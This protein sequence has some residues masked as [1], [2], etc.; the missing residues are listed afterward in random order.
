MN[1]SDDS[2][3]ARVACFTT[4][5]RYPAG[6]PDSLESSLYKHL[7]LQVVHREIACCLGMTPELRIILA[8]CYRRI[9][10]IDCSRDS[11]EIYADWL[12]E[13]E[14]LKEEVVLADWINYLDLLPEHC[15]DC[16]VGDAVLA[17]LS[18]EDEAR[19]LIMSIHRALRPSGVL[20]MRSLV[21][22]PAPP[23]WREIR[24]AY[25]S[26]QLDEA[27]FGLATR[28]LGFCSESYIAST[29]MLDNSIVFDEC[30]KLYKAGD[31]S[32]D[33][34]MIVNRYFFRGLNW[35][36]SESR[37]LKFAEALPFEVVAHQL[38]GKH[39]YQ[40]YQIYE[41]KPC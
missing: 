24:D 35:I 36:P 11:I 16:V 3:R 21:M 9:I 18:G 28:L 29:G 14:R 40:Y 32:N 10:S 4:R 13:E 15:L 1:W 2:L 5:S 27:A 41:L 30:S 8:D 34:F 26:S 38:Q 20:V 19:R 33:E 37:W 39:W 7:V 12:G 6:S 25:R 31:L 22:P 23:S 17:N